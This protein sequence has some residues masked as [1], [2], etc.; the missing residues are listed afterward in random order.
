M[1]N[2]GTYL[3]FR[4]EVPAQAQRRNSPART[5]NR[6]A[7]GRKVRLGARMVN[8]PERR[9][10]PTL[11]LQRVST[12]AGKP[13]LPAARPSRDT[14]KGLFSHNLNETHPAGNEDLPFFMERRRLLRLRNK[15]RTEPLFF[16]RRI[17][18]FPDSSLSDSRF[19]LTCRNGLRRSIRFFPTKKPEGCL[20]PVSGYGW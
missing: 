7:A 17:S 6:V 19:P 18:P 5:G 14:V 15:T 8:E 13:P 4:Y 3:M 16:N 20:P 12:R 2:T 11:I 9:M 1:E 10:N